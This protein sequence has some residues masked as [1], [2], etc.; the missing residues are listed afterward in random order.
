VSA[1]G[2]IVQSIRHWRHDVV[3]RASINLFAR[4]RLAMRDTKHYVLREM[5]VRAYLRSHTVRKLQLGA[6]GNLLAGWLNTDQFPF[7]RKVAFL[8]ATRRFPL[9]D[10]SIDFILSEHHIEHITYPQACAM[11]RECFRVCRPGGRLRIATPDLERLLRLY[12]NPGPE[13]EYYLRFMT[14]RFLTDAPGCSA[15]FVINLCMRM[16]GHQFVYDGPTL[17]AAIGAAGFTEV[18]RFSPGVSRAPALHGVDSHE[19]FIG[20]ARVNHYETMVYEARRP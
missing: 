10:R 8:D 20:D 18:E 15:A 5:L 14:D 6:G 16:A 2:T 17:A 9:P 4:V 3:E 13:G 1:S 11:L 19:R 12:T 7:S